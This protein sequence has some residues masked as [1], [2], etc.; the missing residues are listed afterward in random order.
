MHTDLSLVPSMCSVFQSVPSPRHLLMMP[1]KFS[2]YAVPLLEISSL[3]S[4]PFQILPISSGWGMERT[5]GPPR[6]VNVA[7]PC[8]ISRMG[9]GAHAAY[10]WPG[11]LSALPALP[12]LSCLHP[13]LPLWERGNERHGTQRQHLA[14]M[15]SWPEHNGP[16]HGP[17]PGPA[18]A[19]SVSTLGRPWWALLHSWA[20][21]PLM[22]W[23]CGT[24]RETLLDPRPP[25]SLP[26]A[27]GPQTPPP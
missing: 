9:D 8:S 27:L 5:P 7:P 26:T 21:E 4:L 3:S 24:S 17:A 18:K 12:Q 11:A 23:A 14:A 1:G 15:T 10:P 19:P 2:P 20:K 16:L 6:K 25:S 22:R 13:S